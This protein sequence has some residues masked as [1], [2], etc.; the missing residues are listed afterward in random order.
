MDQAVDLIIAREHDEVAVI[1]RY[2]PIVE[3]YVQDMKPDAE[4]G[5][6]PVKDHYFLGQAELSKG[7]VDDS[8]LEKKKSKS[9]G[10]NPFSHLEGSSTDVPRAFSR[11]FIS[12]WNIS[13][14]STT[15]SHTSGANSSAKCAARL[16]HHPAA[17]DRQVD[18]TAASGRKIK[19]SRLSA[20]TA[21]SHHPAMKGPATICTLIAGE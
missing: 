5:I 12:T 9:A 3:T 13:I 15:N 17:Q 21:C 11:W 7:I 6:V 19:D 8:M 4:M 10:F 14:A 16:R 2:S 1:R 18:S 20:S